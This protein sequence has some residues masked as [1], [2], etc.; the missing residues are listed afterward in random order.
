MFQAVVKFRGITRLSDITTFDIQEDNTA[1]DL[2]RAIE[3]KYPF[4]TYII[5]KIYLSQTYAQEILSDE[6]L[7]PVSDGILNVYVSV[8]HTRD[9][10]V[11]P[12]Q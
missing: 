4:M 6:V 3:E 9:K 5:Y 1:N 12:K 11:Q 2:R 7:T 10:L 8:L